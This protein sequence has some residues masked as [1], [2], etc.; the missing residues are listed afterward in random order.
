MN[1][2]NEFRLLKDTVFKDYNIL[3]KEYVNC[4]EFKQ[5]FKYQFIKDKPQQYRLFQ[6]K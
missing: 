3:H 6:F 5:S 2:M 1:F 4:Y